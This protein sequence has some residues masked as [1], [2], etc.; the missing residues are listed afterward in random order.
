MTRKNLPAHGAGRLDFLK[1]V[2]LYENFTGHEG[3]TI[4]KVKIPDPP[5][6]LAVIGEIKAIVYTTVRDNE[7]EE[8]IHQ[9]KKSTRPLFCV[10]PDGK[11]IFI[12]GGE[13]S[14]TERGII[15]KT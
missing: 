4:A 5:S 11:Q 12:V 6:S 3:E 10:S 7:S 13:Y 14:F 1:A 15:D 8:Y 9:F 2:K